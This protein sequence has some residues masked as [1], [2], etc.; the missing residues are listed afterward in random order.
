MRFTVMRGSSFETTCSTHETS[1]CRT[2]HPC[3]KTNSV[4]PIGGPV[5]LPK[6]NGRNKT[7]F[8]VSDEAFIN[9]TASQQLY[10]VPTPADLSGNLSDLGVPIY[11]PYQHSPGSE[12]SRTVYRDLFP[13][14]QIPA[15][16][17]NK[18]MVLFA[19][20]LFPKPIDTGIAGFNG[21]DTT[22]IVTDQNEPNVRIDQQLGEKDRLFFRYTRVGQT[23]NGS[24]GFQGLANTVNFLSYNYAASWT[25]TFGPTAVSE[26]TF[27]RTSMEYDTAN[28]FRNVNS[29]TFDAQVGF[30]SNFVSNFAQPGLTLIPNMSING[31]HSGR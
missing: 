11:N 26:L 9:H 24:G 8:Y 6:Y 30:A 7:F 22:P 20:T 4:V 25:H 28:K 5:I 3:G 29:A 17:L 13:N 18:G 1:S 10:I 15:Q 23:V 31:F 21:R 19:K 14:A 27:G 16:Y 12:Q 2:R